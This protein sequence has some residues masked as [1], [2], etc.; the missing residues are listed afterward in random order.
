MVTIRLNVVPLW[1]ICQKSEMVCSWNMPIVNLTIG[2]ILLAITT[3]RE[4]MFWLR[5]TDRLLH[6]FFMFTRLL[7]QHPFTTC[8]Y[9]HANHNCIL[10]S[11]DMG[12]RIEYSIE[13]HPR[14]KLGWEQLDL[15]K[16]DHSIWHG[17][18]QLFLGVHDS[19]AQAYVTWALFVFVC[20]RMFTLATIGSLE[21]SVN[22]KTRP[23]KIDLSVPSFVALS[24]CPRTTLTQIG[25]SSLYAFASSFTQLAFITVNL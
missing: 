22:S 15:P 6:L 21:C 25:H 19:H 17:L 8:I 2:R 1:P 23:Q 20:G 16:V 9:P 7:M 14:F 10:S 18:N 3:I 4:T 12:K 13:A 5:A 11:G 24:W